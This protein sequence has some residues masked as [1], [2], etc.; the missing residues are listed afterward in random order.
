MQWVEVPFTF[1]S[2]FSGRSFRLVNVVNVNVDRVDT[3][4]EQRES[5]VSVVKLCC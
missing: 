2:E 3:G 1:K 5:E 4:S